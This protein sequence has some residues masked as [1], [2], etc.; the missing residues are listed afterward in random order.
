MDP[1]SDKYPEVSP[2]V[3]CANNPVRLVDKDGRDWFENEKTGGIYY[4]KDYHKGDEHLIEG[5]GWKWM[6]ENGMFG[7]SDHSIISAHL[8]QAE[9]YAGE[10]ILCI[11]VS[12]L[13]P[14]SGTDI[15]ASRHFF[16]AKWAK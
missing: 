3:Y 7:K 9:V 1:M 8:Q 10:T 11:L 6:G 16:T 2:Y 4:S 15:P 14:Q 5:N 12:S 13:S